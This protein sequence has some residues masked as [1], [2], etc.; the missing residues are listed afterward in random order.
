MNAHNALVL[1]PCPPQLDANEMA[2]LL[3]SVAFASSVI[4]DVAGDV[5]SVAAAIYPLVSQ[6]SRSFGHLQLYVGAFA[7]GQV[8]SYTIETARPFQ[9]WSNDMR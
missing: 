5:A 9:F 7:L 1:S 3:N 8:K 4:G 6:F 2:V